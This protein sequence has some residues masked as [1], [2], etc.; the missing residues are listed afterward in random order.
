[1]QGTMMDD[2]DIVEQLRDW[3]V[4]CDPIRLYNEA[5]DEIER[6]RL[7]ELDKESYVRRETKRVA[8]IEQLLAAL[9]QIVTVCDDNA[10]P[11]CEHGMA[12]KFVRDI[13]ARTT[14]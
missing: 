1:M 7:R 4:E 8:K 5:A 9:K 6:L 11:T 13:A 3:E 12:L 14:L 2:R 10:E